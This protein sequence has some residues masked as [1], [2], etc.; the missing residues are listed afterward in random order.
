MSDLVAIG[1][2]DVTTADMAR[3]KLVELQREGLISI[4]DAAIVEA[5]ADGT[6]KL[7]QL[8]SSTG[9]GA[10]GGALWGGL[11]GLLFFAPLFGMAVGAAGGALS[12]K[13]ADTGVDDAFMRDVGSK[14]QPGTAALF[15]LVDQITEDKVVAAM[16]PYDFQGTLL[17]T[18]LSR[19]A[20]QHLVD[21]AA[22]ARAS[23]G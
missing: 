19:E 16:A 7:H 22:T 9:R 18:S 23:A 6:V 2:R 15:L 10:T 14:L 4:A 1:Y 3:D 11:I 20:E 13:L 5:R 8:R 21:A 12:G 17:R